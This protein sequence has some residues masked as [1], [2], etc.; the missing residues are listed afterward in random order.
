VAGRGV[1][2][3]DDLAIGRWRV[4]RI[5]GFDDDIGVEAHLLGVVLP[6]VWVVPE[7]PSVGKGQTVRVAASRRYRRLRLVRN[8]V[9]AIVD[10]KPIFLTMVGIHSVNG[11]AARIDIRVDGNGFS[12]E[13]RERIVTG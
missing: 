13:L 4:R 1:E 8:A 3:Q 9:V 10:A 11:V 6:H 5:R 2:R 12:D 7:Q